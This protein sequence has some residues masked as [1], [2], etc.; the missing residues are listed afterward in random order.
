MQQKPQV[1]D[2]LPKVESTKSSKP[3][4]TES[5]IRLNAVSIG[6][7]DDKEKHFDDASVHFDVISPLDNTRINLKRYKRQDSADQKY[8]YYAGYRCRHNG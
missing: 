2:N 7:D 6:A 3:E 1:P 4:L 5:D 8:D